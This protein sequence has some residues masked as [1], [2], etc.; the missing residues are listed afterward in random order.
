M[1]APET[2]GSPRNPVPVELVP[3]QIEVI[4]GKQRISALRA[5][6]DQLVGFMVL[7]AIRTLE[8]G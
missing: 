1:E 7:L 5:Y 3:S 4:S 2:S 6:F 8:I